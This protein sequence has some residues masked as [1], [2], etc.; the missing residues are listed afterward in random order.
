MRAV[1]A[2]KGMA[3]LTEVLLR[4]CILPLALFCTAAGQD[5]GITE[6]VP[7]IHTFVVDRRKTTVFG[8]G[9]RITRPPGFHRAG[10][11]RWGGTGTVLICCRSACTRRMVLHAQLLSVSHTSL[12]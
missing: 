10:G 5:A 6:L 11:K 1:T 3:G 7:S 4:T 8:N 12:N 9:G 2:P